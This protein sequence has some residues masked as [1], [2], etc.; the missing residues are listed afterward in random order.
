MPISSARP[1]DRLLSL[2]GLFVL[3]HATCS[4]AVM[5]IDEDAP[6]PRVRSIKGNSVTIHLPQVESWTS[7]SF[8]ARAAVEVKLTNQK[9]E[10]LGVA[11]FEAHGTVDHSNRLVTLD[12]LEI[13]KARFPGSKDNGSNALSVLREVIPN[14]ARTVS[15]DYLI[16][17]L[18][19]ARAA[20]REAGGGLKHEPPNIIWATNRTVL[21]LIDGEPILRPIPDSTLHRVLN[22]PALLLQNPSTGKFYLFGDS[23]W[24][25][26]DSL[27][28]PWSLMTAVPAELAALNSKPGTGTSAPAHEDVPRLIVS[29]RPA[30]LL[31]TMGLPDFRPLKGTGLQYAADTDSQLFFYSTEREAYLLISGRWYKAKSLQGP[32]SYVA[33]RDLPADFARIPVGSPQAVV[34]ASVPNTRQADLAL[35][36]NSVP[37]TATINR[38]DTKIQ[39]AYDGEPQ[40]KPIDGTAMQYAINAELPV[41]R[42]GEKFYALDNAV[43]FVASSARGPWEVAKEVPEEIY[44]IPPSSP[45][46]YATYARVYDATEDEAEV[47]YTPGYRGAYEE[48][49]TVVYG[50]GWDYQPWYGNEYYGWGWTC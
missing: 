22:T 32:W 37:T 8:K 34:L 44:T 39:L 7:N 6:W 2:V 19:F 21:V 36:G 14:E 4:N 1:A 41:I 3:T 11:W 9:S 29:T 13:T 40:F 33:P 43:W 23:E 16:T 45:V 25:M 46:Y 50:T 17:T 48:D 35:F 20:A 28:S 12:S 38:H 27:Q 10:S 49:G 31:N 30:E 15:L 5:R 47:G 24:F 18:G 42:V 26:A